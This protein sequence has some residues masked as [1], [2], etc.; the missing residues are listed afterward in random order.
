MARAIRVSSRNLLVGICVERNRGIAD[1]VAH[2]K[3]PIP[4]SRG[5]EPGEELAVGVAI[6]KLNR[7]TGMIDFRDKP[8]Y[9]HHFE[10]IDNHI[11]NY[12]KGSEIH[13]FHEI[14]TLDIHLDVYMIKPRD[15]EYEVLLTSGMSSMKMN[16]SEVGNN[17]ND[18]EFAELMVL[19]P[20]GIDFG[21]IYP[22]GTKYDWIISMIKQSA[23]FPHFYDT[24]IGVGHTLQATN[25][26]NPYS[27]DTNYCGCLV[28]PTMTFPKD[29]QKIQSPHGIINI[30][31]LFPLYKEELEFKIKN[32]FN[33]FVKFLVKNNTR[34][35]IEFNRVNYCDNS[36]SVNRLRRWTK[37]LFNN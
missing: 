3:L 8:Q 24:W 15:A 25:D 21:S 33:E 26:M 22:G 11:S 16:V 27:S 30:Y 17:A 35:V 19:I 1:N 4:E 12:F 13:V 20:K 14:P 29:F 18:Y 32:G 6:K 5:D 2:R 36:G 10:L 31:S 37:S 9:A 7:V 23:K 34:E 28:L